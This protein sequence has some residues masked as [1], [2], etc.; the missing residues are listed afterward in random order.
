MEDDMTRFEEVFGKWVVKFRWLIIIATLLIVFMAASGLR[1]LTI[2]NDTRVMFSEENPQLKALEALENTYN[3]IDN[4]LFVIAPKDENVFT[5]ETLSAVEEL[6]G[7]SWQI[8]YSSRV[9]SITNF[10]HT[11]VDED[12]LIVEDLARNSADISDTDLDRIKKTALSEPQ[13]VHRLVSPSGHVTGVNVNVLMPGKSMNEVREVSDFAR[14]MS[15]DFRQRHRDIDV[16]LTGG[17]MFDKIVFRDI[18]HAHHYP[19]FNVY[20]YGTGG[21]AR[22]IYKP[23]VGQCA[24]AHSHPGCGRQRA[25]SDND[26]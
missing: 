9:D 25:C 18:F 6:T 4:V 11:E 20:W 17:V 13:L 14:K 26:F 7:D 16:Y 23:S 2:N 1:F 12:D 5:R 3:K 15:D 10:Q 24:Y 21:L 22:H 19:V 8:P